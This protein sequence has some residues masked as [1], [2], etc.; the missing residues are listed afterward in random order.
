MSYDYSPLLQAPDKSIDVNMEKVAVVKMMKAMCRSKQKNFLELQSLKDGVNAY[1]KSFTSEESVTYEYYLIEPKY[2]TKDIGVMMLIHGGAYALPI[3]QSVLELAAIYA[4]RCNIKVYVPE[5]RLLPDFAGETALK[6]C[7]A[8][9]KYL[10]HENRDTTKMLVY[11]ESAGA[12]LATG[13]CQYLLD[14]QGEADIYP[15]GEMLIYPVLDDSED[16]DSKRDYPD[17]AWTARSNQSMWNA[18]LEG[19]SIEWLQYLIPM[20]RETLRG[21]PVSY[22]EPQEI[23][24]L[25]DEALKYGE[26]LHQDDVEC[27]INL[28]AGS[29]H[30]FDSDLNSSFVQEVIS[31]RVSWIDEVLNKERGNHYGNK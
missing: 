22:V 3:Q 20:K 30:S 26:R 14:H 1:Q 7:I 23:D 9:W 4:R 28:I 24:I 15:T 8:F 2:C 11:G 29:Y 6:D 5:Y 27:K 13:L 10:C 21:M 16:Y 12:A 17:A 25:R 19:A 18:Y 31:E